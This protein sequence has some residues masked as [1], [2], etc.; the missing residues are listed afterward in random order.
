M[1]SIEASERAAVLRA[2]IQ[3]HN[4]LYYQEAAPEISDREYDLLY[5]ELLDLERQYP[6]LVA[7][8][9][10]TRRVGGEPLTGF[11]HVRHSIPMMSLDNTYTKDELVEFDGRVKRILGTGNCTYVLEPKID[12]VAISL[13]YEDGLLV[14]G[15]TRGDGKT[16][17]DIT[18]NLRT[19]RSIPMRLNTGSGG[20]SPLIEVRGEVYMTRQ[21]F[22]ELNRRREENGEAPFA[23]PRNAAAGSLK[24]LDSRIVAGRPLDAVL[25]ALGSTEGVDAATHTG[26]LRQLESFGFRTVPVHWHCRNIAE[27]LDRLDELETRR[28]AFPFEMD[29]GVIKVEERAL[30]STLGQTAKSPRWA[31]AYKYQPERAETV[32]LNIVVQVGRTGVLTPVANLEPVTVAGSVVSRA[33]L[34]NE[35]EVRRKDIR[36]G[37]RVLIEK[38]G[39]VIPAVVE[40]KHS[41]RTGNETA[42]EIPAECPVCGSH[43]TRREGEV[44]VRCENLQCPAQIKRWIRHF[45]SRGAMDIEGLGDV[46]VEQ[47]VDTELVSDPADLYRLTPDQVAALE[48]MAEKSARNLIDGIKAST[49]RD[50]WRVIFALGIRHVG[51]RSAQTIEQHFRTIEEL[52]EADVERLEQIPDIGPVVAQAIVDFFREERSRNLID[53]LKAEGITFRRTE[54]PAASDKLAG[55]TFV[56]T[57]SLESMTRDEA[58][59][60]IRA[61]GGKVSS[62]VS[63]KTDFVVAGE[64]AGSKLD[65]ARKLGVA[66]IDEGEF[67]KL[68][69]SSIV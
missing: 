13:R 61:L 2:A 42:F 53:R 63:G 48:R 17:D 8:D 54:T 68:L 35:D 43:V 20:P 60:Q 24:L 7:P 4:A 37:D 55:R 23:N 31:I 11:E 5:R 46:L 40:V 62:S 21:G 66:V 33:T 32:V 58:G 3:R 45:A 27:I 29:G 64:N 15:S 10:P 56:L 41:A 12:G 18:A 47:L 69:G 50:F 67:G 59:E 49:K 1:N 14:T 19:I 44:A 51:A 38:A 6:A 16:G 25:Y 52:E 9:S 36:I 22:A 39:E 34:H 28:H 65:K 57:G 30:Y 26:L